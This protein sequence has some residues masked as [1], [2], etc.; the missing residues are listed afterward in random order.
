MTD[1]A[2]KPVGALAFVV[3]LQ[4]GDLADGREL[5]G[6]V[7]HLASGTEMR[8][9]SADDLLAFLRRLAASDGADGDQ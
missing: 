3:Q 9:G 6:R 7:E 4:H 5:H 1:E 8:F 2:R